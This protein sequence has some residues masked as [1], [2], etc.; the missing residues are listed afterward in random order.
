MLFRS[1]NLLTNPGA[2]DGFTGWTI[3]QNGG[4]GWLAGTHP[5]P[6]SGT[7]LWNTSYA[8]CTMH[9]TVDLLA[10]GYSASL[11]D[12]APEIRASVYVGWGHGGIG[13]TPTGYYEVRA[14][15]LDA[16]DAVVASWTTGETAIVFPKPW[17]EVSHSFAGYPAGARKVRLTL[18]GYDGTL[19]W[20]GHYGPQF[21]EAAVRVASAE[22][23]AGETITY[24]LTVTNTGDAP[25]YDVVIRDVIPAG[26]RAG[27]VSTSS[28]TVN[29][30]GAPVKAPALDAGFAANGIVAWDLDDG[31]T[32]DTYTINAGQTLVLVYTTDRK[33]VV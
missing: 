19:Y 2:E 20:A 22:A 21:D 17:F 16:A 13:S 26:M 29:G 9:Q 15:L 7:R 11:L 33:S 24:T 10:A 25:A 6:V 1:A 27:G 5:T 32:A 14:E 8:W 12:A 23:E 28:I 18:R 31:G 30:S 4:S 3:T